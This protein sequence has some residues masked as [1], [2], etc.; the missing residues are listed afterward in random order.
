MN[1][2]PYN[3]DRLL[4]QEEGQYFERKSLWDGPPGGKS[5]RDRRSVRDDIADYVAAFANADGGVLVL[6]VE[7]DRTFTGHGYPDDVIDAFLAVPQH[8]LNPPQPPGVRVRHQGYELLIFDVQAA[9]RAVMVIGNGFPRR[10]DDRVILES[11]DIIN[12]IKNRNRRDSYEEEP[13]PG[14]LL[15]ELD[16]DLIRRAV[17]SAGLG[18]LAPDEYLIRRRL[19]D[20]HGA[21]LVLRRDAVLLFARGV[22]DHP[23]AGLR[24]FRVDGTERLTGARHNVQE[25][26]RIEA[27][28][29]RV[30]EEAHRTLS[31]LI[32]TSTR[33]H[34]LFFRETPEYPTFAWQEAVVNAV[35][36]RDYRAQGACAEVWLFDNRMEVHS[37]GGLL[38]EVELSRLERRE[39]IHVSRNPRITRVLAELAI[40][41]E[42]GEGIPRIF[43]EMEESWLPLP[44]LVSDAYRFAITLRN[45]PIFEAPDPEWVDY[46]RQLSLNNR[47]ER[48]LVAFHRRDFASADYQRLNRVDRDTAYR[49][50]REMTGKGLIDGPDR[51]G[52]GARYQVIVDRPVDLDLRRRLNTNV[53]VQ[54]MNTNG[55]VTNADYRT[56]FGVSSQQ[57]KRE[58]AELVQQ[59]ILCLVGRGRNA[60]YVPE[61]GWQ[62]WVDAAQLYH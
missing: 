31:G 4:A 3:L 26:P 28:L 5:L 11:E 35:A 50:L 20:R 24:I 44:E 17:A 53:L 14:V 7:D 43:E 15:D 13:C 52:R 6:G 23:N 56:C 60:H 12:T 58:L 25:L 45:T 47:Q 32:R 62:A 30:V 48:I 37:P 51:P 46:V 57:A 59:D 34:D 42:Q 49:D 41:R 54:K 9:P 1:V 18:D 55:Y 38:P 27:A 8:R 22:I 16:T 19:A 10:C 21:D 36:H 39:R 61:A 2:V 33:L 40:M 29:P